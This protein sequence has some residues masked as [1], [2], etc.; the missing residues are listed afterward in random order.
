MLIGLAFMLL[1]LAGASLTFSEW[2]GYRNTPD[3]GLLYFELYGVFTVFLAILC[4]FSF[5][6]ARNVR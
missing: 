2:Q 5:V 4:L 3:A 1:T 6:R